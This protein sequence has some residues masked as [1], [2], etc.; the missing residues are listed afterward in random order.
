MISKILYV[1]ITLMILVSPLE[2]YFQSTM[3]RLMLIQMPVFIFMGFIAGKNIKITNNTWNYLGFSGLIFFMASL[4]FWMLPHSF[5]EII[6][7]PH[8]KYTMYLNMLM[9][10][11]LLEKS[12]FNTNFIINII[13]CTYFLAMLSSMGI[14]YINSKFL[15]CGA[16]TIDQQWVLGRNLLFASLVLFI[17]MLYWGGYL[18]H[19][20]ENK[21]I[22]INIV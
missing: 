3:S 18:L 9:A 5:D 12:L 11:F 8:M 2:A 20:I 4:T 10:G 15:I 13:F 16:F 22:N 17:L 7:N 14:L 21:N 1:L 19:K 6:F